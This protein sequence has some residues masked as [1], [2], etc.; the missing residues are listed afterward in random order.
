MKVAIARSHTLT[1]KDVRKF[2]YPK[3]GT[4]VRK[5]EPRPTLISV[6]KWQRVWSA[7]LASR[8]PLAR[9]GVP[10]PSRSA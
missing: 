8:R 10:R 9:H 2:D 3:G 7:G 6:R 5:G 4:H 1:L